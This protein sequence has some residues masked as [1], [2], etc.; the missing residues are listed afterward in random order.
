MSY[1]KLLQDGDP[2]PL[3]KFKGQRMIDVPAS[4]LLWYKDSDPNPGNVL[5]YIIRNEEAILKEY[6]AEHKKPWKAK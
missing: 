4:Y 2:M 1:I 6:E 3:G 5:D